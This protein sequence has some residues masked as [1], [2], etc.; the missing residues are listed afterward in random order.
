MAHVLAVDDN[1]LDRMVVGGL[2][3]PSRDLIV[4][5]AEDGL[6]ALTDIRKSPPDIVITDMVMPNLDGLELVRTVVREF[7][8]IPIILITSQGSEE[9]AVQALQA[10]AASYVPKSHLSTMLV[11]TVQKLLAVSREQESMQRLKGRIVRSD[12]EVVLD[13]DLALI[14]PLI[15][16]LTR[17]LRNVGYQDEGGNIRISVALEEAL[18]NAVFHGNLELGSELRDLESAEYRRTIQERRES[19]PY[20]LRK[21]YV[22]A[23]ISREE[24]RFHIRD[25]GP[26]FDPRILPD[27]TDPANLERASGRGVMLMRTFMNEV[28]F[29]DRGNEVTLVKRLLA[30]SD[31]G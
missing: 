25:E 17:C 20:S 3:K 28:H 24:A 2:L 15:N 7:P 11:E 21:V 22:K 10:G 16:F 26:G 23:D 18:N 9:I 6:A 5:Y 14:P 8:K 4:R 12:C 27:P 30:S 1:T 13:N 19:P 29:S 31:N